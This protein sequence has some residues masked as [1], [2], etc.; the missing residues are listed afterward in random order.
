MSILEKHKENVFETE[1]V[2]Y[3]TSHG[4]AEGISQNYDKELALYP[5]DLLT[6]IKTTQPDAYEKM[7]KREGSK[8]DDVLLKF[9]AKELDSQG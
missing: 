5:E 6:Y 9:V 7:L 8:T 3:L 2:D 1:I 4:W